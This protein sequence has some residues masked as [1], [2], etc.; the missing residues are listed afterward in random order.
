MQSRRQRKRTG[1]GKEFLPDS[2][3]RLRLRSGRCRGCASRSCNQ[4]GFSLVELLVVI[5]LL[6]LLLSIFVPYF[7]SLIETNR[8][9]RCQENLRRIGFA[10]SEYAADNRGAFPRVRYDA[11]KNPHGFTAFTGPDAVN[12]FAADSAVSPNDVTASLWLL[13]RGS[14]V[15]SND[16]GDSS[17]AGATHVFVCPSRSGGFADPMRDASGN[18][19]AASQRGNFRSTDNLG[20]SYASP[21][22]DASGYGMVDFYLDARFAILADRNPGIGRGSD[23]T[24]PARDAAPMEMAQANSRN[25]DR[26]GQNVLFADMHVEFSSTPYCGVGDDNIYT[27]VAQAPIFTGIAPEK[28]SNGYF[29]PSGAPAWQTDSFLVPA[30]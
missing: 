18:A 14:Y 3:P 19:I 11:E 20:Y 21:F 25:H 30:D 17:G 2:I 12:P 8:R 16:D 9:T 28:H 22:S 23:V 15:R 10:L 7:S 13:V 5:G 27:A 29:V 24:A 1:G 6:I 4:R 26:A